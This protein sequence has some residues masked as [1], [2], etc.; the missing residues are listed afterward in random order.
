MHEFGHRTPIVGPNSSLQIG[1]EG[2]VAAILEHPVGC[3][4]F[5]V[6][7]DARGA[8]LRAVGEVADG[9]GIGPANARAGHDQAAGGCS[10]RAL[11]RDRWRSGRRRWRRRWR[12][13]CGR[14][15]R[16]RRRGSGRQ[17]V[18]NVFLGGRGPSLV[19]LDRRRGGLDLCQPIDRLELRRR[20][21]SNRICGLVIGRH[22]GRDRPLHHRRRRGRRHFG[23][24]RPLVAEHD[25][26]CREADDHH[27]RG[28]QRQAELRVAGP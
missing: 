9:R 4:R 14:S 15:H 7:L 6:T 16:R 20:F 8:A 5:R 2:G 23:R 17:I 27:Q 24:A 22:P 12:R 18:G 1:Q 21:R 11:L 26:G 19:R 10:L 25:E 28:R 13:R 3:G